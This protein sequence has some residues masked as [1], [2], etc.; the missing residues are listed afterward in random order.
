MTDLSEQCVWV[1][2]AT[3]GIGL[4]LSRALVKKG[5]FVIASG[6]NEK[7][8]GELS[9]ASEGRLKPLVFDVA[10]SD[11]SLLEVNQKLSE[12][13]DYIDTVVC[14]AGVCEYEDSLRFDSAM[15]QRVMAVNFLGVVRTL[16]LAMPYLKRS[17]LEPHF[18]AVGS[19]SS[20]VGFPRAEAYGSSKA[21]V[22][23]FMRSLRADTIN[24]PLRVS[25]IR[26]GFVSTPMTE[27]ND[28]DMP[29]EMS[30]EAAADAIIRGLQ[31]NQFCI[32]FP[33]RLSWLLR[34]F[35]ALGGLWVKLAA[36][37]LTRHRKKTWV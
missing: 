24:L 28:F 26:P 12:L 6:R 17:E 30:A 1:T 15:Y 22:E 32:D 16:N 19:L 5:C 29:F 11:E 36:P 3:S 14:C 33:R 20:V 8:L 13:T 10:G 37:K 2:G 25:L 35:A 7:A 21:A 4:A 27:K 34:G 18:S 9:L 23:Y 31:R